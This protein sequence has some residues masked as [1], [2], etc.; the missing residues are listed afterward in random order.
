MSRLEKLNNFIASMPVPKAKVKITTDSNGR[1]LNSDMPSEREMRDSMQDSDSDLE[2]FAMRNY[3]MELHRQD[4][5]SYFFRVKQNEILNETI[6][7]VSSELS[8]ILERAMLTKDPQRTSLYKYFTR[9]FRHDSV[10]NTPEVRELILSIYD[11]ACNNR[12]SITSEEKNVHKSNFLGLIEHI[13]SKYG[14]S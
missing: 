11:Y 14:K 8:N 9:N 12:D 6:N 1:W 3:A 13:R 2:N 7:D 5:G 4:D 10:T